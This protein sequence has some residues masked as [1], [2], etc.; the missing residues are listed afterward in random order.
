MRGACGMAQGWSE[1]PTWFWH[2]HANKRLAI[3]VVSGL[4]ILTRNRD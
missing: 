3:L 1:T 4:L 2:I